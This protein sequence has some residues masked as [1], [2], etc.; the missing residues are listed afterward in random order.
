MPPS[1][2]ILGASWAHLGPI[3]GASWAILWPAGGLLGAS[4]G[5]PGLENPQNTRVF[6]HVD[7]PRI[8]T[9]L[10]TSCRHLGIVWGPSCAHLGPILAAFGAILGSAGG[11]LEASCGGPGLQKAGQPSENTCF[12]VCRRASGQDTYLK[13]FGAILCPLSA[14][15]GAILGPGAPRVPGTA[16][17]VTGTA[18]DRTETAQQ[19]YSKRIQGT[20]LSHPIYSRRQSCH[21][22]FRSIARQV[23]LH[24]HGNRVKTF[25]KRV[26]LPMSTYLGLRWAS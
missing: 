17:N 14:Q 5:G 7:V 1:W 16:R 9:H 21:H 10:E 20:I 8:K 4:W 23:Q 2:A 19:C 18:K 3:L 15:L 13:A 11:L 6:A 26:F 22:A 12:C 24:I 25:G